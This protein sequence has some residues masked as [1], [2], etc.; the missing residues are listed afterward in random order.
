MAADTHGAPDEPSRFP[1][2]AATL[3]NAPEL[4]SQQWICSFLHMHSS[5]PIVQARGMAAEALSCAFT[6]GASR[7]IQPDG[8]AA[9]AVGR[10]ARQ[11]Q[12]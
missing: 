8:A 10:I 7:C 5:Q 12:L 11:S 3:W 1:E 9:E 4:K 2:A 6:A